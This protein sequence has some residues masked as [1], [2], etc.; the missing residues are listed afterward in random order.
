M[1]W[2]SIVPSEMEKMKFISLIGIN[3]TQNGNRQNS[4]LPYKLCFIPIWSIPI[5]SK[6]VTIFQI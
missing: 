5:S 2:E 6:G 3:S 1:K 4:N